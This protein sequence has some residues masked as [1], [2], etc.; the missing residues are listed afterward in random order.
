MDR[1]ESTIPLLLFTGHC[2]I[3]ADCCDSIILAL[4]EYAT[5]CYFL[6][7]AAAV[8]YT[9]EIRKHNGISLLN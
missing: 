3:T 1:V 9:S 5:V 8:V 2:L 4:S 7:T 6:A